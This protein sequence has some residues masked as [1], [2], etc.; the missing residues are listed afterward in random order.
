MCFVKSATHTQIL[1]RKTKYVN[2]KFQ[3]VFLQ[4]FADAGKDRYLILMIVAELVSKNLDT[5]NSLKGNA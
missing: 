2:R 5:I 3:A 1:T 4:C